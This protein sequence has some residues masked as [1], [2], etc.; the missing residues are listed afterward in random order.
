MSLFLS[1]PLF[2]SP[3]SFQTFFSSAL[4]FS[5]IPHFSVVSSSFSPIHSLSISPVSHFFAAPP[6]GEQELLSLFR[7]L[8]V[9]LLPPNVPFL[10]VS[11]LH[12][13][14]H[15]VNSPST[16]YSFTLFPFFFLTA[17][18]SLT[19][20]L[21]R[22]TTFRL[23]PTLLYSVYPH[24]ASRHSFLFFHPFCVHFVPPSSDVTF[25]LVLCQSLPG[26]LRSAAIEKNTMSLALSSS[27]V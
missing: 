15:H 23:H 16:L 13:Y 20:F 9:R 8:L 26:A 24:A 18:P 7:T 2:L 21:S 14:Q 6:R 4:S 11:C 12:P 10:P 17:A 27:V 5:F 3:L 19:V 1:P 25:T 22:C